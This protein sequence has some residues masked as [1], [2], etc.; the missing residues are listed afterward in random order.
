MNG[1]VT[2]AMLAVAVAAAV[3]VYGFAIP[4]QTEKEAADLRAKKLVTL[5]P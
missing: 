3:Y 2:L 4:G 1:R 5:T